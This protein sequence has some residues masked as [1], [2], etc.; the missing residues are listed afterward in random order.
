MTNPLILRRKNLY[1]N[2]T[3]KKQQ[4]SFSKFIKRNKF[5]Y[6]NR[7]L[8]KSHW[9]FLHHIKR[10]IQNKSSE[11]DKEPLKTRAY[12][13]KSAFNQK[14]NR[15]GKINPAFLPDEC[16][17]YNTSR[18]EPLTPE[19]NINEDFVPFITESFY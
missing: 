5:V 15:G 17:T 14:I 13:Q 12:Y 18:P 8:F 1:R 7:Q 16:I 10:Y 11:F 3:L 19:Q 4:P 9:V 2:I 6:I